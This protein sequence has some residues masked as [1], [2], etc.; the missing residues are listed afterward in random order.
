MKRGQKQTPIGSNLTEM[1]AIERMLYGNVEDDPDLEAELLALQGEIDDEQPEKPMISSLPKIAQ[2]GPIEKSRPTVTSHVKDVSLVMGEIDQLGRQM[3]EEACVNDDENDTSV[4]MDNDLLAEFE[5]LLE[6][7]NTGN[8]EVPKTDQNKQISMKTTP[9]LPTQITENTDSSVGRILQDRLD[10]YKQAKQVA[11]QVGDVTKA[12]RFD[13]AIQTL[14][15]QIVSLKNG[16]SIPIDEIPPPVAVP[17]APTETDTVADDKTKSKDNEEEIHSPLSDN[18]DSLALLE[19]RKNEYKKAALIAKQGFDTETALKY[20]KMCKQFDQVIEAVKQGQHVDLSD[21]PSSPSI[22]GL[23]QHI[24]LKPGVQKQTEKVAQTATMGVQMTDDAEEEIFVPQ[25]LPEV[26]NDKL[27][28]LNALQK[29]MEKYQETA[30]KAQQEDD[31]SKFRRMSRIQKQYDDAIRAVKTGRKID[32]SELPTP[33]GF[34]ALPGTQQPPTVLVEEHHIPK[35]PKPTLSND[36]VKLPDDAAVAD[37][38]IATTTTRKSRQEQQLD[39]LL[40]R[41]RLFKLAALEAKKK[42]DLS[43]AKNFLRQALGL[44]KMIDVSQSGLPVDVTNVPVPPQLSKAHAKS[45]R[46]MVGA[47]QASSDLT[48]DKLYGKGTHEGDVLVRQSRQETYT[49][50][51]ADL[52]RQVQISDQNRD[53]FTKFGDVVKIKLFENLANQSQKDLESLRNGFKHGDPVPRFHYE[54]KRFPMLQCCP[55]LGQDD[56]ELQIVRGLLLKLPAGYEPKDADVFVK[57]EFAYPKETPQTGKTGSV[58]GTNSPSF[59][60]TTRLKVNLK[61]RQF[62]LMV[63]RHGFKFEVYQ[64]GSLF[65]SDKL[66]G[67]CELKLLMLENKAEIHDSLDLMEGRR[68]AGGKLEI[69]VRIREPLLHKAA[70][71]VQEKW[72]LIDEFIRLPKGP[73]AKSNLPRMD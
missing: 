7:N 59:D 52:I 67:T 41:Q 33:P 72:L 17:K 37:P 13:R 8:F 19:T 4:E 69:K 24:H 40:E 35:D 26:V 54:T 1:E 57:F 65:R 64:K 15:Q 22:M 10:S 32:F 18:F 25:K 62:L 49:S 20:F 6:D 66:L 29:R 63:K 3:S 53:Y 14:N 34:P 39:F 68:P 58:R 44:E 12:R 5:D 71:E 21:I 27:A 11:S 23:Q 46:P 73:H 28:I 48:L 47:L 31:T 30:L 55:D 43:S 9:F 38:K 70:E 61:S 45:L 51:E 36:K 2:K 56:L 16:K 60:H 42:G 50:L